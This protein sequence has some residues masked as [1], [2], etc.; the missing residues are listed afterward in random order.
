MVEGKATVVSEYACEN[1]LSYADKELGKG[2]KNR[3]KAGR[4]EQ[5]REHGGGRGQNLTVQHLQSCISEHS[6]RASKGEMETK[7]AK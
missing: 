1:R 6:Y 3:E 5:Q 2:D 4:G 7:G